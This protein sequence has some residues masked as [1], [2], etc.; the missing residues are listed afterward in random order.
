[1]EGEAT[2]LIL[3]EQPFPP[4]PILAGVFWAVGALEILAG[5]VLCAELWPGLPEKGYV[6][7]MSAYLPA[8]TWL[9]TGVIS[10]F[11]SWALALGLSYLKGIYLNT[12]PPEREEKP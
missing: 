3:P 4:T 11:L 6:W 2:P 8:L 12:L 5:F 1:M 9:A 7:R 10:G